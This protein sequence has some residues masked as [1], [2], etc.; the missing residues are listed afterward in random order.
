MI[1]VLGKKT[2]IPVFI[3]DMLKGF[4]PVILAVQWCASRGYAAET[5]SITAALGA[6]LGHN[7][8]FWLRFKGGK[9][10]ATSA[11]ALLAVLPVAL[12]VA[13]LLWIVL[14]YTTRYVAVASIA[15]GASLPLT[16][17][18][19]RALTGAPGLPLLGL[20]TAIGGLAVWRHRANIRRLLNGTENRFNRRSKTLS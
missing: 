7:F 20:A 12:A 5:A 16:V 8:T 9:G 13:L 15:A 19:Q 4:L 18:V 3:L 10:V 14:F 11:G 6:V 17:L 1:R 2:G